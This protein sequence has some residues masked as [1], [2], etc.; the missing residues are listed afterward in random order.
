M[1][2]PPC[3]SSQKAASPTSAASE[4]GSERASYRREAAQN[5]GPLTPVL[6]KHG[7]VAGPAPSSGPSSILRAEGATGAGRR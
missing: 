4:L 3:R 2:T 5:Q 6:R 1:R 7:E